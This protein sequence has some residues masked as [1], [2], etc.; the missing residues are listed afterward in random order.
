MAVS[1]S[2]IAARRA[3]N[4]VF[5]AAC[6]ALTLLALAALATILWSL[7]SQGLGGINLAVFTRS[8]PAPG[9]PGGLANAIVGSIMLA[10]LAMAL[11]ILVGVLAGTWLAEYAGRSRY[12]SLIRFL[13]DVLLSAPSILIGL[14]VYEILVAPFGG[15]SGFAG[16]V[17]LALL[18]A[19]VITRTTEDVL[20]LQAASLRESAVAL[21]SPLWRVIGAVLWRNGAS[22]IIT[23][24]LLAFARIS[25][26]TAPLLFTALNNQFFSLDMTK[27]IANLPSVIFQFALSAYDDWRRLAW[28]GA[29]LI[30]ATVLAVTI[31]A[32]AV[33]RE[34]ARP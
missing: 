15:F 25:G 4:V 28:A 24:I 27:P 7:A 32:R 23:G 20:K 26:E 29:L 6:V 22:G 1:A 21:G 10:V 2:R 16:A 17:A 5:I 33:S 18:A 11:A 14:F 8:T 19:P 12:G 30:A 13:N 31:L 34:P 3:A 9:S